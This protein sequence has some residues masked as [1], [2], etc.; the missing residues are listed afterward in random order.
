MYSYG[1]IALAIARAMTDRT[2]TSK[3]TDY[4]PNRTR[5][6]LFFFYFLRVEGGPQAERYQLKSCGSSP[7]LSPLLSVF[8]CLFMI[9]VHL[10]FSFSSFCFL[11]SINLDIDVPQPTPGQSME[12]L[13]A[14]LNIH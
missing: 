4:C 3:S 13:M 12:G 6:F 5:N 2:R 10:F 9:F 11:F 1:Q 7:S 14:T 8:Y